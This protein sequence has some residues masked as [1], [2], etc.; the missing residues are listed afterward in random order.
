MEKG[1]NVLG[2]DLPL[3]VERIG[4]RAIMGMDHVAWMEV[5]LH[6]I[7]EIALG[8]RGWCCLLGS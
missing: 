3:M 5:G 1:C 6:Q 8:G 4:I 2:V 7:F